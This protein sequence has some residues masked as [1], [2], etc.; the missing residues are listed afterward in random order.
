M[1]DHSRIIFVLLEIGKK[2]KN[3]NQFEVNFFSHWRFYQLL[4]FGQKKLLNVG[5]SEEKINKKLS[6]QFFLVGH[7]FNTPGI[8]HP[9][10]VISTA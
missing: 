1:T 2:M 7:N 3:K 5:M 10:N 8:P 9:Q 6:S 4:P